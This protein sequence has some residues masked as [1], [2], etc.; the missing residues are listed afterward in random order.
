MYYY[1]N[2]S[3]TGYYRINIGKKKYF[4]LNIFGPDEEIEVSHRNV[5]MC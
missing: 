4:Q 2:E 1:N 3:L 5:D